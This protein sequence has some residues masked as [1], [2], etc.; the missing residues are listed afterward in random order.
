M[1]VSLGLASDFYALK[2][3]YF[4]YIFLFGPLSKGL[5][6]LHRSLDEPLTVKTYTSASLS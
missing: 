2:R 5:I 4:P 3:Q 1:L 6:D